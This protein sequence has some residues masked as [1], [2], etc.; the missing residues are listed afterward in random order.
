MKEVSGE[1][2][3]NLY[4]SN[5]I[6]AENMGIRIC[7]DTSV[8]I[9]PDAIN[10]FAMPYTQRLAQHFGGAWVHYC[11]RNDKLTDAICQIPEIRGI[12]FGHIPGHELDHQFEE[13]MKRCID[14]KKVYFGSWPRLS[15]E[16]GA[17][18]LSR[19]HRWASQRCLIPQGN[20]ALDKNN[21]FSNVTQA[22]D[23]WYNL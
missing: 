4:H 21:G 1:P 17:E 14:S 12:N 7:E 23:Y 2:W 10:E 16:S 15:G 8:L 22:L 9:S 11:G 13:D 18:H 6:Y 5:A 20:P 3:D 19:L